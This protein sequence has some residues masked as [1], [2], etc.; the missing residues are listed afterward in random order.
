GHAFAVPEKA[1]W[2]PD[3]LAADA[4]ASRGVGVAEF[5]GTPPVVFKGFYASDEDFTAALDK[6]GVAKAT[7][8]NPT[9]AQIEAVMPRLREDDEG[10]PAS[11]LDAGGWGEQD[12]RDAPEPELK[13]A[14]AA[15]HALRQQADGSA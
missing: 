2:V 14:A 4:K 1:P 6:A 8:P 5:E 13:G 9:A 10:P 11:R 12:G 3:Y 7:N 15:A